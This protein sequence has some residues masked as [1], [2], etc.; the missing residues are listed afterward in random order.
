MKVHRI[1]T[2]GNSAAVS[3]SQDEL[4]HLGVKR[5]SAVHISKAKPD[6]LIIR[7]APPRQDKKGGSIDP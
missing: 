7:A 4:D 1:I 3:L 6:R 5:G 2:A